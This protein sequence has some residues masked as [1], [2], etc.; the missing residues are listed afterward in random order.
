VLDL[1]QRYCGIAGDDDARTIRAKVTGYVLTLDE[2]LQETVPALLELLDALPEDHPF[3]NL[4]PPQRRQRTLEGL[5]RVLLRESQ[6]QPLRLVFEDL[7]WID[8][9]TQALLDTLV[10]SLPTARM[11]RNNGH[12]HRHL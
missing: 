8:S 3:Q 6:V 11:L 9:E 12:D 7:H 2:A 5:K 4:D 1:L 10:E